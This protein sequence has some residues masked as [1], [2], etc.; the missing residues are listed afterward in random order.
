MDVLGDLDAFSRTL[1]EQA[2]ALQQ[3]AEEEERIKALEAQRSAEA[4]AQRRA[5]EEAELPSL[6]S[7]GKSPDTT[8]DLSRSAV[9]ATLKRQSAARPAEGQ[10]ANRELT[11]SRIDRMLRAAMKYLSE[12]AV[13]VNGASPTLERP[14]ELLYLP[15]P[16]PMS[17][18]EAFTDL[19]SRRVEGEEVCDFVFLKFRA[20]YSPPARVEVAATDLELCKR[21]LDTG[22]VP[23]ETQVLKKNDFGQPTHAAYVLG[24]A[25]P[26]EIFLRANYDNATVAV[27][28]LNIGRF[29]KATGQIALDQLTNSLLDEIGKF[30]LGAPNA[31]GKLVKP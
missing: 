21:L 4:E 11:R 13:G 20:S 31:F 6:A 25:I 26:C 1:D 10:G 2:Q 19:R 3:A 7:S 23:F 18:T 9:L 5:H 14:Y 29:G 24:E 22:R 12:I 16:P 15:K 30:I 8:A 28:L 17:I 27:E